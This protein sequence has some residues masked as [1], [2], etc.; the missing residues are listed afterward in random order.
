MLVFRIKLSPLNFSWVEMRGYPNG[1]RTGT[2]A[3]DAAAVAHARRIMREPEEAGDYADSGLKMIAE[4][5]W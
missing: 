3:S 5:R 4:T 1:D 2:L